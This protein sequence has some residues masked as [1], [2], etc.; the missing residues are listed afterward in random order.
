MVVCL[1]IPTYSTCL[2]DK[3]A[4]SSACIQNMSLTY[5]QIMAL[6]WVTVIHN[7]QPR[8]VNCEALTDKS[9]CSSTCWIQ[10]FP[11]MAMVDA[12]SQ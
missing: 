8:L 12:S 3:F 10:F 9:M 1:G 7:E 2:A 11:H 4:D 5:S 6:D